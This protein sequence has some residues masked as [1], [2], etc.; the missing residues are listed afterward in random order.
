MIQ[1][2][3]S[4]AMKQAVGDGDAIEIDAKDIRQLFSRLI[5]RY[6]ALAPHIEA[7]VAVSIDGLLYQ[8][9]DF[10]PLPEKGEV[11]L[12]PRLTGG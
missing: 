2:V 12:I 6:P 8:D 3:L 5:E 4:G 10:E 1:V 9:A 7:G 11:C